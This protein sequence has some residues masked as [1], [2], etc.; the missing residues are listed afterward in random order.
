MYMRTH[1]KTRTLNCYTAMTFFSQRLLSGAARNAASN[2]Y[3]RFRRAAAGRRPRRLPWA[4]RGAGLTSDAS[5]QSAGELITSKLHPLG[6]RESGQMTW[7]DIKNRHKYT[8]Q[9]FSTKIA[10]WLLHTLLDIMPSF[11]ADLA[12]T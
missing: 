10:P 6:C 11:C 4:T 3:L 9:N 7:Y 1:N 8:I 12:L 5:D 2:E